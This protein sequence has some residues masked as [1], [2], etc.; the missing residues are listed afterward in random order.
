MRHVVLSLPVDLALSATL[1]C[2]H[3]LPLHPIGATP[4]PSVMQH[5]VWQRVE[6]LQLFVL[7]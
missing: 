5:P 3:A 4:Y 1:S 7:S 2:M 6:T